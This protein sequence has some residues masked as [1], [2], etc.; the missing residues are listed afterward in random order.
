MEKGLTNLELVD[1]RN[2]HQVEHFLFKVESWMIGLRLPSFP[3][4]PQVSNRY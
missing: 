1:R 2:L 4:L 3:V